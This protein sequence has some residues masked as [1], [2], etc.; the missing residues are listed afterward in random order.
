MNV[1]LPLIIGALAVSTAVV[2]ATIEMRFAR[3]D[4]THP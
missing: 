1:R 4:E 2:T 3:A